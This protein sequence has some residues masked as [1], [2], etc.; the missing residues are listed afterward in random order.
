MGAEKLIFE[1]LDGDQARELVN[2]RQRHRALAKALRRVE[3]Y[4]GSMSFADRSG[5]QYLLRDYYDPVSGVRKQ[6][7]LGRRDPETEAVAAEFVTGK[8]EAGERL[9][10]AQETL[11]RQA[12][13]NR[14]L[15]L[16]RVPEIGARIVRSLD[17]A[18]LLGRGLRVIGT[19]ALFAYEAAAGVHLGSEVLTTED[20]DV[21]FDA[22]ARLRFAVEED[23]ADRTLMGLLRRIDGTFERTE[24][25]FQARNATGYLVDLVRPVRTPPWRLEEGSVSKN[26]EDLTAVEIGGLVWHESAPAFESLAIDVKGAPVRLVA[27][28]PRAFAVHKLWLSQRPDRN[29]LKRRRDEAQARAAAALTSRYLTHLPFDPAVLRSFPKPLV[30]AAA[31]LFE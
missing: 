26:P 21:L 30:E 9:K 31:P 20:I 7:S 25:A 10:K 22:R 17:A 24:A 2:T 8:K 12:G 4:R 27:P 14:A 19:N 1:E 15:G 13:V 18:G 11:R 23:V 29:P 5:A 6:K 3:G 16:G 28:D